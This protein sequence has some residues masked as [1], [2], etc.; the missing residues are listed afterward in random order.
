MSISTILR[1]RIVKPDDRERPPVPEGDGADRA[2]DQ[3]QPH[4]DI[5]APE[6]DRLAGHVGRSADDPR[7]ADGHGAGVGPQDDVGVQHLEQRVEVALARSREEGVEDL[8]LGVEVGV[9][10]RGLALD[11]AAGAARE[12]ARRVG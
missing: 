1:L 7:R 4:V 2:A 11:A 6:G 9:G 10:D 5:V 12:L 8:A 3:R